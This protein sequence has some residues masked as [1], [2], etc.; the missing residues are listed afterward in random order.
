MP[1]LKRVRVLAVKH[2]TTLGTTIATTG[3]DATFNA[4]DVVCQGN[5]EYI[6]R[7]QQGSFSMLAGVIG[8]QSGTVTFK[9]PLS[10]NGAA[11]SPGWLDT[12]L[13]ACGFIEATDTFSPSSTAPSINSGG[14]VGSG[15]VHTATIDVYENGTRKSIVGAM[16]TFKI[17]GE[18]GKPVEIE[19]T[20]TGVWAPVTDEAVPAPTYDA[21][22]PLRFSG[23][24]LL[25][26]GVAPGC[27]NSFSIDAGNNVIL[28]PCA[29]QSTG[30]L[31]ALITDRKCVG[32]IDPES[33]LV[34]TAPDDWGLWLSGTE[35]AF[36][37]TLSSAADE[38]TI[39][40]PQAQ[41]MNIQEGERNGL[42]IDQ[43][44]FAC[45]AVSGDDELT[46]SFAA[47]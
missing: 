19:W 8:A 43:I 34:A 33:K 31:T 46:I 37:L 25:I 5:L 27:V 38:I 17:T 18:I 28:R 6:E 16:G 20:F 23:V 1:L 3:T 47:P 35:A 39:A 36:S 41:R 42:Q 21:I 22:L 12:L 44:D 14:T 24:G 10:G 4:Y 2:E 9:T 29:T 13:P 7:M 45:N 11:A 32:S 30:Y 26:G 15:F 40:A